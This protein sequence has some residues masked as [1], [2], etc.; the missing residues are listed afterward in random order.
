MTEE[1]SNVLI[2]VDCVDKFVVDVKG[3]LGME[4]IPDFRGTIFQQIFFAVE[5]L[6][7]LY[8]NPLRVFVC[9]VELILVFFVVARSQPIIW[10]PY[11][12]FF[13]RNVF[14]AC[15]CDRGYHGRNNRC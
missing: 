7:H 10:G 5:V 6:E 2:V 13:N 11:L 14:R 3:T 12:R 15:L 9:G 8:G 4:K 1:L